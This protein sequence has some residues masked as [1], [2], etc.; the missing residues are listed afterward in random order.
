[1]MNIVIE[2]SLYRVL[3]VALAAV[4]VFFC[5]VFSV[6]YIDTTSSHD[7]YVIWAEDEGGVWNL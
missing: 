2:L 7:R 6:G 4:F 1:M 5:I 3:P